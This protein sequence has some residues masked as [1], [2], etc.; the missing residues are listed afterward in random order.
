[1]LYDLHS[2]SDGLVYFLLFEGRFI[3]PI[4]HSPLKAKT[5]TRYID[6]NSNIHLI[7]WTEI[8]YNQSFFLGKG[9]IIIYNNYNSAK[10][11]IHPAVGFSLTT[12]FIS[13]ALLFVLPQEPMT[14]PAVF[15]YAL[16]LSL[17]ISAF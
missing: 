9:N 15:R 8:Q 13:F 17:I 6:L 10:S 11:Q 4:G 12:S 3:W 5:G 7:T 16:S 14:I 2:S 1:M